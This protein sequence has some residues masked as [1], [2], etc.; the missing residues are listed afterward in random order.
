MDDGFVY[1]AVNESQRICKIGYSKDVHKR[2][3]QLNCGSL[4]RLDLWTHMHGSRQAESAFHYRMRNY[5][6]DTTH[7]REF[8]AITE[9]SVKIIMHHMKHGF[10]ETYMRRV[11]WRSD[12]RANKYKER[13]AARRPTKQPE[14][15]PVKWI[16]DAA[17]LFDENER[18]V[19][20]FNRVSQKI[21]P[22]YA[23]ALKSIGEQVTRR[24][25]T[26]AQSQYAA[27]IAT[28]YIREYMTCMKYYSGEFLA[29]L[30]NKQCWICKRNR[31]TCGVGMTRRDLSAALFSVY[32]DEYS[33]R[34]GYIKPS[35][36][37]TEFMKS[38][39][40]LCE[41]NNVIENRAVD[42]TEVWKVS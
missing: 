40:A 27:G 30:A 21:L 1:C 39:V 28:T 9:Q 17:R 2:V 15:A 25:I 24:I 38:L 7:A 13:L 36:Q 35:K 16:S 23:H 11:K 34:H 4:I 33:Y 19:N 6:L 18:A 26:K 41:Q 10:S 5:K 12:Y 3:K 14:T 42:L 32:G 22:S 20:E 29:D 8:F 37:A 31:C